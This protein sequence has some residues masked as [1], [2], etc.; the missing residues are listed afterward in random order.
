MLHWQ[1]GAFDWHLTG[2]Y[3]VFS[4][5]AVNQ[6]YHLFVKFF[7]GTTTGSYCCLQLQIDLLLRRLALDNLVQVMAGLAN[8]YPEGPEAPHRSRQHDEAYL[9]P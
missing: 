6:A 3:L 2:L 1:C 8:I 7:S 5:V 9:P 4:G